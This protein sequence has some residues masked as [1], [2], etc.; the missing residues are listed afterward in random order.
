MI[1][2]KT[3]LQKADHA[4]SELTTDGGALMEA[5]AKKFLIKLIKQGKLMQW[6]TVTPI[7]A[8]IIMFGP[9]ASCPRL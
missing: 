8:T 7:E 6:A 2:N 4:L 5:Q 1:P 3:L 9:G